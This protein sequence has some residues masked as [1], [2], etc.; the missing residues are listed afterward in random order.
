MAREKSVNQKLKLLYIRDYL[1]ENSDEEHPVS[2]E[3]L[4]SYLEANNIFVERKTIYD[5]IAQLQLYGEDILLKK[6]KNGGYFYA[7]RLFDLPEIKMLV[8]SV[9]VSKF[10]TEAQSMSLI[11]KIESLTNKHD[12]GALHRQV[13]VQNRVKTEQTNIFS[14][15]DHI[16]HAI[17]NNRT[18]SF[19]YFYYN[20]QKKPEYKNNGAKYEISPFCLLWDDENYYMLG[21]DAAAGKMKHYRVD[22][23][24]NVSATGNPRLGQEE[25]AQIDISSYNK[26]V[27]NMYH[28]EE[29]K[30]KIRFRNSLINV[31][32]DRFGKNVTIIPE[33]DGEYFTVT[34]DVVVSKQFYAWLLGFPGEC[35]ILQPQE[36][37]EELR[38]IAQTVLEQ[39]R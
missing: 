29:K 5:D 30:V 2:T 31:V 17:N 4:I 21:Y 34:V 18:V 15:I 28:G 3:R 13:V 8:D 37:R 38:E 35:E 22:R 14:N 16:S 6:G 32:L 23:M 11:K 26:K 24:K 27:F 33:P 10:I 7:S 12:A 36:M 19:R 20:L 25:Y 1:L 9:Q 39:Y